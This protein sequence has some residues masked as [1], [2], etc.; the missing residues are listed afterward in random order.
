MVLKM[1]SRFAATVTVHDITPMPRQVTHHKNVVIAPF[2]GIHINIY[3]VLHT[4]KTIGS[5]HKYKIQ[6]FH[7]Y[8]SSKYVRTQI[9]NVIFSRENVGHKVALEKLLNQ[10]SLGK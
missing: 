7:F 10:V 6:V 9:V 5:S 3:E 4:I 2:I 8:L 1:G